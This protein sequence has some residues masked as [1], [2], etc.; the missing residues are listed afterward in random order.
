MLFYSLYYD[1]IS[2]TNLKISQ[3][4]H[5]LFDFAENIYICTY[6]YVR[7]NVVMAGKLIN[8]CFLRWVHGSG[9][10]VHYRYH[11]AK[12]FLHSIR[13][14]HCEDYAS[15]GLAVLGYS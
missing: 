9:W 3:E 6:V 11:W 1:I 10:F 14:G 8:E 7:D 4:F 13:L 2:L 12:V 15:I 5:L